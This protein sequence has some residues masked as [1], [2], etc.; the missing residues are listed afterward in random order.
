MEIYRSVDASSSTTIITTGSTN[1]SPPPPAPPLTTTGVQSVAMF[2]PSLPPS[3]PLSFTPAMSSSGSIR[4][5]P[6]SILPLHHHSFIHTY[7]HTYT[8]T[9]T[10]TYRDQDSS[11]CPSLSPN[12]SGFPPELYLTPW[13]LTIFARTLDLDTTMQLWDQYILGR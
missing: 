5:V 1:S 2:L 13:L 12:Q 9:Y 3:P 8:H 6:L 4:S 11:S 7:I 10:H